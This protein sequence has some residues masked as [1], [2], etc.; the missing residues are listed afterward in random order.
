MRYNAQRQV[1]RT[2][3]G[4]LGGTI[5]WTSVSTT[6][7]GKKFLPAGTTIGN[8]AAGDLLTDRS[9]KFKPLNTG[10]ITGILKHDVYEGVNDVAA[11]LYNG[12]CYIEEI[13]RA[14]QEVYS[15]D[16]SAE[17]KTALSKITFVSSGHRQ[18]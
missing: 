13:N 15:A 10:N 1:F 7:D 11:I 2:C 8:A 14:S 4:D 16:I 5:D 12:E 3:L 9:L 18:S 17:A 6:R